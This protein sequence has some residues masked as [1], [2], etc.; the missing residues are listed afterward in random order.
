MQTVN[1]T[2]RSRRGQENVLVLGD[3]LLA[4]TPEFRLL[5]MADKKLLVSYLN[6][7]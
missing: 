4:T 1:G 5:K 6:T 3:T 7:A 2:W